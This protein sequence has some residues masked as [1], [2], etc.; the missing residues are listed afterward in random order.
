MDEGVEG[1]FDPATELPFTNQSGVL[2]LHFQT[3]TRLV[4]KT[5]ILKLQFYSM[6]VFS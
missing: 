6:L 2:D 3:A 1:R 5:D 4:I